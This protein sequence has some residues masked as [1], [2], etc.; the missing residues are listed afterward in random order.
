M[1]EKLRKPIL[2][3]NIVSYFIFGF[4]CLVFV[5]IGV[6]VDQMSNMGGVALIVNNQVISWSEYRNYLELI[7]QQSQESFGSDLET[8]RQEQLKRQAIDSLLNM[9]LINQEVDRLG[10][11][12]SDQAVQDKVLELPFFQEEGRFRH[13]K[14]R[15]FLSARRFSAGYFENLIRKEIQIA[16]FQN[17]FNMAV[18]VSKAEKEKEQQLKFFTIKVSY[19]SFSYNDLKTEEFNNITRVVQSGDE[20]M[21]NQIIKDKKWQ[22]E[23]TPSFD[24]SHIFLPGLESQKILFDKTLNHLPETGLIKNI[25]GWRDQSFIL[26]VDTFQLKNKTKKETL[27][28]SDDFFVN[29]LLAQMTFLSWIRSARSSAKLKFSP[30]LQTDIPK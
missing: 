19:I 27:P 12:S 3:K 30:R 10:L 28:L 15:A 29:R 16:Y 21:L 24:L 20:D 23:Q 2:A 18:R 9:E 22:W 7:E 6:P 8:G 4:I 14:Y 13:S 17:M 1:F 25:I 5:F 11:V 26:R